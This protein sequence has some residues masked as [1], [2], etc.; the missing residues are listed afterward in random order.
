MNKLP[1]KEEIKKA[2]NISD[3]DF[4]ILTSLPSE[5]EIKKNPGFFEKLDPISEFKTVWKRKSK[6]GKLISI[7]L[8]P[9]ALYGAISFYQL[10]IPYTYDKGMEILKRIQWPEESQGIKT[11]AILPQQIKI[12]DAKDVQELDEYPIGTELIV[13]SGTMP[14]G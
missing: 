1:T 8:T 6:I 5:E 11:I 10:A 9:P 13:V 2:Y 14:L 12:Q 7:I 4:E 3:N